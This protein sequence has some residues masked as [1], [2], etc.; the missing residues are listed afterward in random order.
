MRAGKIRLT[1]RMM[2]GIFVTALVCAFAGALVPGDEIGGVVPVSGYLVHFAA[3][4]CLSLLLDCAWPAA[5]VPLKGG[6]LVVA[7][8]VIEAVQYVVPYRS[9]SFE[10]LAVDAAG[11][12]AYF[13][14]LRKVVIRCFARWCRNGPFFS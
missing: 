6:F 2:K 12:A 9:C 7:G 10:D 4:F 11:V 5:S 1:Q 13:L 8:G 14:F 3:F